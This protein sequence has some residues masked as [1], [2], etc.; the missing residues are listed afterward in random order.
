MQN[1]RILTLGLAALFMAGCATTQL[2]EPKPAPVTEKPAPAPAPAPAPGPVT[3]AEPAPQP[4]DPL[5]DP[6][7]PLAK[8]EVFFDFDK[9]DIKPE[10]TGLVE[11]HGR[12]LAQRKDR[13]VVIEGNADERGSREY[14]LALG[15]KRADAVRSRLQILGA[16]AAQIETISYGEERPRCKEGNESC[17][18]QNRRADIVYK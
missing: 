6:K 1:A 3:R 11:A 14:N 18:S 15:Q 10:F 7:S 16:T 5:N 17:W 8:R 2:E 9:F 4:I 13:R 12:Y